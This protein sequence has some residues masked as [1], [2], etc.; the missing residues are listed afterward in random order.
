MTHTTQAAVAWTL[1]H[2]C[3]QAAAIAAVYGL[4]SLA[5]ARRTSHARYLLA[6]STLLLMLTASVATFAWE[7]RTGPSTAAS[8]T[9]A[10]THTL[11]GFKIAPTAAPLTGS[12]QS[13]ESGSS[14]ASL[15]PRLVPLID[16]FWLIGVIVLSI[17]SL[18][19]WWLI[20]RLRASATI[21]APAALQ[22]GFQRISTA[23]GIRRPVLLRVSSAI[24][25]PVTIGALR[26]FVLLPLSAATSLGQDELEVVLAHEL[27]HVRR[28]DF[29]WNLLQTLV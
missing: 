5:F 16:A 18:G 29:L 26:A 1:I 27:A 23:L 22:A 14:L 8:A 3:W 10:L 21:E 6:L 19:G 2:F 17:R 25:G 9:P 7:M 24:A 28:A 15:L 13:P 4:L 20:Q 12:A 11:A